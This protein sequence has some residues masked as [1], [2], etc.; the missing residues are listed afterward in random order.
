MTENTQSLNQ[1]AVT[2]ANQGNFSDAIACFAR[3]LTIE[4]DNQV[5]WYNLGV[6]YRQAGKYELALQAFQ[7]ALFIDSYD[8]AS[9]EAASEVCFTL[10]DFEAC[11]EYC[12]RCLEENEYNTHVWNT[13]GAICFN[14]GDLNGAEKAFF[15][16]VSIDP[17]Y[18]DALYNLRDTYMQQGNTLG[19]KECQRRIDAL[20]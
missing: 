6:T 18:Y 17:Y 14:Q 4:T 12:R 1:Q 13:L 7:K 10:G 5:L 11:C 2:L 8:E 19:Q 3:A 16:A 9:L 20:C 15:E